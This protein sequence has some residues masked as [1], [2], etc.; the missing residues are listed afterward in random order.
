MRE[1]IRVRLLGAFEVE[2]I[3]SQR[4]G[5]RKARALLKMLVAPPH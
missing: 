2:G 5:S 1:G 3:D 4:L